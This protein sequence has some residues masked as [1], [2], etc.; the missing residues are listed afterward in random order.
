MSRRAAS[1]ILVLVG[2]LIAGCAGRDFVRPAPGSLVVGQTTQDEVWQRFGSP[3][4]EGSLVK[5]GIMLRTLTYA[6][7]AA[8]GT[9]LVAG[10]TPARSLGLYFSGH[11]LV[12]HEFVSSYAEDHTDFDESRIGQIRR[13]ET[14]RAGVIELIGEPAGFYIY[15]LVRNRGD[16]GLVYAYAQTRGPAVNPTFYQKFLIVA[17]GPDGRVTDVDFTSSGQK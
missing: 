10:V 8:G 15:P 12:G 4:T 3:Y 13:G 6:F 1:L 9:P 17:I 16:S 14:T 2:A 7:S 11:V 5:N